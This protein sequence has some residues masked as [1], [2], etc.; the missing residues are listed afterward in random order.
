MART[1][2]VKSA[3]RFGPRYGIRVRKVVVAIEREQRKR[4]IC[5]KCGKKAVKRAGT[6]IWECRSCG[7]KFAGGTYIPVTSAT[8]MM[9]QA[10]AKAAK[11]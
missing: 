3:G 2:K 1:K 7:H 5:R 6:G 9:E 10:A 4:Y 8:K 11:G